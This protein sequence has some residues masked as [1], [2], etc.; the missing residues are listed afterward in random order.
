MPI[1]VDVAYDPTKSVR[2]SE[3]L[4]P[5]HICGMEEKKWNFSDDRGTAYIY[6]FNVLIAEEAGSLKQDLTKLNVE[7]GKY[8]L[9][10]D[11]VTNET[12]KISCEFMVGK[13]YKSKGVFL[14]L[15]SEQSG[16]NQRYADLLESLGF[17]LKKTEVASGIFSP[18][19]FRL[20]KTDVVG[21]P[22][23]AKLITERWKNKDGE[24]RST[25]KVSDMLAWND[26]TV[27]SADEVETE[28]LPF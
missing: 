4:Y 11:K 22:V 9:V 15:S 23:F 3:G 12:V 21:K 13:R 28:E 5:A 8:E 24:E 26:G 14:F 19:L 18:K 25:L 20:E 1:E 7:T 10:K 17:E 6:E 27:L 2:P 16:R